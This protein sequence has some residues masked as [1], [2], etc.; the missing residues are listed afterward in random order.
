MNHFP[1]GR[2]P[3][4][5]V[6]NNTVGREIHCVSHVYGFYIFYWGFNLI[7]LLNFHENHRFREIPRSLS[8]LFRALRSMYISRSKI[9][10]FSPISFMLAK[11]RVSIHEKII[12]KGNVCSC[13]H[14]YWSKHTQWTHIQN[15]GEIYRNLCSSDMAFTDHA[16]FLLRS[17]YSNESVENPLLKESV[18]AFLDLFPT[19]RKI[20]RNSSRIIINHLKKS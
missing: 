17:T 11:E 6:H 8:L 13:D 19:F 20:Y 9:I 5:F 1:I 10:N 4:G 15:N 2:T 14:W 3:R 16:D 12:F 18:Q 7:K